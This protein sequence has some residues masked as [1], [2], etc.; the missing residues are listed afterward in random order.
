[1][2]QVVDRQL[3]LEQVQSLLK[4]IAGT[5][6]LAV[7][8]D[9]AAEFQRKY[10]KSKT[11]ALLVSYAGSR[12][13]SADEGTTGRQMAVDVLVL[14]RRL[15]GDAGA[16]AT[17][18]DIEEATDEKRFELSGFGWEVAFLRDRFITENDEV[19]TY[20]CSLTCTPL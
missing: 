18:A 17:V 8:P 12:R 7:F 13:V 11:G 3:L 14:S 16:L 1:M 10:L 20:S 9:S 15:S 2:S 6:Q 5:R 19:Y 4:P